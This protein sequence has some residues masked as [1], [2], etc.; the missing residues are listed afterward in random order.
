MFMGMKHYA[1]NRC[2]YKKKTYVGCVCVCGGGGGGGEGRGTK[3]KALYNLK[4]KWG[5]GRGMDPI[6]YPILNQRTNGPVNAHLISWLV[7]HKT[8]KTW[9]IYGKEMTLTVNTHIPS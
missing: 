8:Y 3:M 5:R 7:K 4:K 6:D 2:L 1:P 9:K